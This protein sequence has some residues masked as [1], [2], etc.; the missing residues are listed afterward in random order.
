MVF[1][2]FLLWNAP[3][4]SDFS[5]SGVSTAHRRS[6]LRWVTRKLDDSAFKLGGRSTHRLAQEDVEA[7]CAAHDV[8]GVREKGKRRGRSRGREMVRW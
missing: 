6:I 3:S 4:L 5:E 1:S 8:G 2:L 7:C